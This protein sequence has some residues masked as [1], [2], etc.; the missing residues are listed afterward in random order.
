MSYIYS[1]NVLR[2]ANTKCGLHSIS[3]GDI[4]EPWLPLVGWVLWAMVFQQR[5]VQKL[6][7]QIVL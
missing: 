6:Q 2:L 4:L 1:A 5:L 7:D 3:D